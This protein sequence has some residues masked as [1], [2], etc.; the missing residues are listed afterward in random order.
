MLLWELF[1]QAINAAMPIRKSVTISLSPELLE[2]AEG[3]VAAGRF[4]TVSDVMRTGL[5]LLEEREHDFRAHRS[6]R[7]SAVGSDA[8]AALVD[9]VSAQDQAD[10]R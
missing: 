6:A 4:G 10:V 3:L 1:L 8:P 5:R 9:R 2:V 7:S